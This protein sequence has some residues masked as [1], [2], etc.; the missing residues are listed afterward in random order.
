VHEIMDKCVY[1]YICKCILYIYI[2]IYIYT[3]LFILFSIPV[4]L[5][6]PSLLTPPTST[7]PFP[8]HYGPSRQAICL[9]VCTHIIIFLCYFNSVAMYM[10]I[11]IYLYAY[12]RHF[13]S[14]IHKKRPYYNYFDA[15]HSTKVS[16]RSF[17]ALNS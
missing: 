1:I 10:H 5:I 11:S 7:S 8:K 14:L 6:L 13:V 17:K 3:F 4:L 2:Y 16:G 15:F 12:K 9:H